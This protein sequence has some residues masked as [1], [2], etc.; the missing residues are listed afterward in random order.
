MVKSL[1][2]IYFNEALQFD[3]KQDYGLSTNS[4][5]LN[6]KNLSYKIIEMLENKG[7]LKFTYDLSNEKNYL[8]SMLDTLQR[9]MSTYLKKIKH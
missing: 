4:K 3:D 5:R 2:K 6:I 1:P 8:E 7:L 9:E